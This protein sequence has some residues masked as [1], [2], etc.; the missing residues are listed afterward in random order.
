MFTDDEAAELYDRLNPWDPAAWPSDAFYDALV[1]AADSVLDVGCGTGAMLRLARAGGH[2]GRLVGID[3]DASALARARSRTDIEWVHG[4]AADVR[5]D[6]EFALATMVSH[7]FQCLVTDAEVRASL[8]AVRRAL[9]PGGVFAFET[10]HPQARA[11]ESWNPENGSEVVDGRGRK[12]WVE[13]RVEQVAGDVVTFTETTS[14][15]GEVAR[16]D[17]TSLRFMDV[18]TLNGFLTEAGFE[19]EAQYG[20]WRRGPI[21]EESREIVTLARR[22]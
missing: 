8:A 5:W 2:T 12:L 11:W 17:R 22:P 3:P 4:V 7:A 9:R 20:D 15:E 14:V 18:A 16:V 6:A 19:I 21:T 10:R 13:H 1:A